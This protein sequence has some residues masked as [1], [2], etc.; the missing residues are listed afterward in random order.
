MVATRELVALGPV[1]VELVDRT[2]I[3]TSRADGGARSDWF[4]AA[5]RGEPDGVLLVEFAGEETSR[6]RAA[7]GGAGRPDGRARLAGS[8]LRVSGAA[9]QADGWSLRSAGLSIVSNVRGDAKPVSVIE[10][11][12]RA[13]RRAPGGVHGDGWRSSSP[14][15]GP[16]APGTPT[17]RWGVSTSDRC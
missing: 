3:E 14:V 9:A 10:D 1:A 5:M 7:P 4:A 12:A 11:C 15:T 13:A 17:P 16:A 8:T 6:A 2:I